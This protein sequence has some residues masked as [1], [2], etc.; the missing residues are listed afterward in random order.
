M[1]KK[2]IAIKAR[3]DTQSERLH[4]IMNTVKKNQKKMDAKLA[5]ISHMCSGKDH[6]VK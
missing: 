2:R 6:K 4:D 1:A 3:P 5:E